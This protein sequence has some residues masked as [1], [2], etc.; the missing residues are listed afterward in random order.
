[1][2][3]SFLIDLGNEVFHYC[4]NSER[5]GG[6]GRLVKDL[7][8]SYQ[9]TV[10]ERGFDTPEWFRDSIVYQIMVDRF[11]KSADSKV[12]PPRENMVMHENWDDIPC[13]KDGNGFAQSLCNDFSGAIFGGQGEAPVFEIT[14]SQNDILY[15][16]LRSLLEPQSMTQAIT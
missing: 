1:M 11:Y 14:R 13:Y 8:D 3:Y 10:Y 5:T 2:W 7:A 15:S 4:N 6:P 9:I 12:Q 16:Y